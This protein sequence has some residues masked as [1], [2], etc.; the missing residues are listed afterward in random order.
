MDDRQLRL[1][2][3]GTEAAPAEP[4][5]LAAG[6]LEAA[7]EDGNLRHIRIGG[8][9]AIRAISYV[10]RDRNW[11]TYVPRITDLVV[12]QQ[13]GRFIVTYSA[14]CGDAE[15]EFRYEARIEG[16]VDGLRFAATGRA[17]TD[18][19][20]NR[21]GFVVLHPIAGVAGAPVQVLHV[22]G[23]LEHAR[24]PDLIEP[25]QPFMD[26][27]ALTHEV[28]PGLSVTCRMEGDTFEMEDQRNWT[29]ASYKTYVRPIGLPWPF[30]LP[31]NEA[32]EQSVTLRF[33]GTARGAR[34]GEEPV[35]MTCGE[36]GGS[37]PAVGLGYDPAVDVPE[38]AAA[39]VAALA[40]RHLRFRFDPRRHRAQ[41]MGR[42]RA[43][44][45]RCGAELV[46]EAVLPCAGDVGAEARDLAA[47]AEEVGARFA[48]VVVSPAPDLKG[49]LPGSA[50]PDCP[51][52]QTVYAAMRSAFPGIPLGGGQ[53]CFFTELNRKR[54]PAGSLDFM[55]YSTCAT[56]HAGDDTSVMET[57]EC[58]PAVFRSAAAIAQGREQWVGPSA[59]GLPDNPYGSAPAD[60]PENGRKAMA[61]MDP[62]QRGLF[63]AAWTLGFL[64]RCAEAAGPARIRAVTL[65][66]PVGEFGVV[67][68]P[69]PYP[70]PLYDETG[71]VYP[72]FHV[73]RGLARISGSPVRPW[74][75][76]RP[77]RVLG[78]VTDGEAWASNLSSEP[79]RVRLDSPGT[80][81]I[82]DTQRFG[83]AQSDPTLLDRPRRTVGADE[84]IEL[85]PY[86]VIR[87]AF[88]G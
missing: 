3:F 31:A 73:L 28:R 88:A 62:R 43:L 34:G 63:G 17:A 76:S 49:T 47:T 6:P 71:G 21:T 20:T 67:H 5:P 84:D 4:V 60:N 64:A 81:A 70:Q 78:L 57:L 12:R 39:L 23:K 82:L 1:R 18:F 11:G 77:D 27:R 25:Y 7:L 36:A 58:L 16:G 68:A 44:A 86:A 80:L 33:E 38:A 24:F 9:E 40:P 45:D 66:A 50:W 29:D 52:L 46:L 2:L 61:R 72:L 65:G 15:Q 56:V 32:I 35:A 14:V 8:R 87:L 54:P 37:L 26:I 79:Q 48:A 19:M 55:T 75:S 42:A 22:D 13:D 83:D 53:Y 51:P 74:H 41:D 30:V 85:P 10:V 69:T 59:I